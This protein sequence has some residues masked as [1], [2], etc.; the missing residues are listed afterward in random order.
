MITVELFED[1]P[2]FSTGTAH[3]IFSPVV[4]KDSNCSISLPGLVVV[5]VLSLLPSKW[6][7]SDVSLQF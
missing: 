7:G 5:V 4:L 6:V 1:L 3:F 2:N